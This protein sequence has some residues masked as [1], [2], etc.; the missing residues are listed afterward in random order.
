MLNKEKFTNLLA[1]VAEL[2]K[3][4]LSPMAIGLYYNTLKDYPYEQV[5]KAFNIVVKT[6]KY[7]CIPKPA[8]II[9]VIEGK[10]DDRAMVAW[11]S[12]KDTIKKYDFYSSIEFEDKIIHLCVDHL[13]GWMWLCGQTKENLQFIAKDFM[14]LYKVFEK[15]PRKWNKKLIGY[16][17]Q[18]NSNEGYTKDIP[19]TIFIP[20]VKDRKLITRTK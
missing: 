7:N 12:T 14:R 19:K 18:T 2:Y 1:S 16:Y 9:E 20:L 11:Q 8:E 13:G 6:Y 4:D 3:Q 10:E 5:E 15:Y 17:E